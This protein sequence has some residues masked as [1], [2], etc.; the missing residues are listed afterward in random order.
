MG[1]EQICCAVI[2]GVEAKGR[3][4]LE[5]D[6]ILFRGV[7]KLKL[8]LGDIK[9]VSV[10]GDSL[11]LKHKGGEVSFALGA[12]HAAAWAQRILHPPGLLDKLGVTSGVTVTVVNL[13][14]PA[15]LATLTNHDGEVRKDRKGRGAD[16]VLFGAESL[17]DLA[18]L[19]GLDKLIAPASGIW[20]IYP[21]GAPGH[22]RGGR[23]GD[24][25]QPRMEG[26]Q[27]L[28]LFGY[29]HGPAVCYSRRRARRF[30]EAIIGRMSIRD[31]PSSD[32]WMFPSR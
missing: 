10:S 20:V 16:V 23:H 28:P 25:A 3:T 1:K 13:D 7:P 17:A 26:Q 9:K 30:G 4:L 29:A 12:K 14:D 11:V 2:H 8:P 32:H 22:P 18:K 15:F 5:T 31:V 27:D 19:V 24:W 21:K 6:E